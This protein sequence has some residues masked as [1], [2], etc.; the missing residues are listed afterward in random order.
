MPAERFRAEAQRNK[1][2]ATVLLRYLDAFLLQVSQSAV[3]NSLHPVHQRCCRWLLMAHDRIGSD[4][5]R[6]TQKFLALMLTVRLASVSEVAAKLQRAGLIRYNRG[7]LT[8]L[9]RLGLEG[10]CCPCYRIVKAR[11]DRLQA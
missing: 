1:A 6:F 10:E 4:Q 3:C 11:F 7:D 5:L 9:D 8:I 2:L